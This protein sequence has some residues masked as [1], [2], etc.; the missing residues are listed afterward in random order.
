MYNNKFT[1]KSTYYLFNSGNKLSGNFSFQLNNIAD[2]AADIKL[3][4]LGIINKQFQLENMISNDTCLQNA[5]LLSIKKIV[6]FDS[7]WQF[8]PAFAMLRFP[9][10]VYSKVGP[11]W[12]VKLF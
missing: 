1:P 2:N 8:Y 12:H 11:K 4:L 5:Q 10:R 6:E 9:S 3:S 7:S